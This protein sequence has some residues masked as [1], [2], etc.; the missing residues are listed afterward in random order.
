MDY[1]IE[2]KERCLWKML[3]PCYVPLEDVHKESGVPVHV[4]VDWLKKSRQEAEAAG[5]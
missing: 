5:E 1:P 3:A 2:M 4:L